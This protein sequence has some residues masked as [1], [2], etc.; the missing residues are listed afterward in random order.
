[1]PVEDPDRMLVNLTDENN[2][3]SKISLLVQK[4]LTSMNEQHGNGKKA[5]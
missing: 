4:R 3:N 1:M 5:D 2:R